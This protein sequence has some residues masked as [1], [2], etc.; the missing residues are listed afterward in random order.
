MDQTY[1]CRLQ[2]PMDQTKGQQ[3]TISF[4]HE[5]GQEKMHLKLPDVLAALIQE[6]EEELNQQD[7]L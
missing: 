2:G 6:D 3:A 1:P 7:S 4:P 5:E